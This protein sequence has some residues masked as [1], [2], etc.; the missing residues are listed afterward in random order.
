MDYVLFVKNYSAITGIPVNLITENG[1]IY[2]SLSEQLNI[3]PT[4]SVPLYPADYNPEFRFVSPDIVFGAVKIETTDQ[5]I[6]LGPVFSVPITDAIVREYLHDSA[7]PLKY[8]EILAEALASIPRLSHAQFCQH[9]VF[10]HQCV[11][12][13]EITAYEL[14]QQRAPQQLKQNQQHVKLITDN[15]ENNRTHNTYRFERELFQLVQNGNAAALQDF[16][17]ANTLELEE[18]KLAQTP[19]RHTKNLF[20][21]TAIKTAMLGAIPGGVGVEKTYQLLDLY[22]QECEK[23]QSIEK[24]QAL[25]YSMILDFCQQAGETKIPDGISSEI[26]ACMN[27][28]RTHTND[29]ISVDDVADSIQRSSS[30]TMKKFKEEMGFTI[31]SFITRCKLEEAKSLLTYS[32]KSLAEISNYL[33]FSSQPHFQSL[34]KK[35]YHMTP[36]EYRKKSQKL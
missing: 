3:P 17:T 15:M 36:L 9:L 6:I 1:P 5:Y 24:I 19:L 31:G 33:C 21:V 10:L 8:K 12:G 13:K 14:M 35:Q 22:I 11:N 2:S 32:E 34:F 7:T 27:F 25:Q 26:Y 20:I 16:L 29:T 18:G 30:Y 23:L 4:S 28:I